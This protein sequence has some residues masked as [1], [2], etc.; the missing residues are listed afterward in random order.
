MAVR[1]ATRR[2]AD[3]GSFLREYPTTL[4][5]G[6]L[7]LPADALDGE[8][9]PELKVDLVLPL[10]GR[11]G[12][13]VG[14]VVAT[15]PDGGV[16]L[17]VPELPPPV[18]AALGE[19]M[20]VVEQVRTWLLESGQVLPKPLASDGA[21]PAPPAP[22]VARLRARVAE[23]E[24]RLRR[25]DAAGVAAP[26]GADDGDLAPAAGPL[27]ERG[28]TVP[29][30]EG[31]APALHGDL[32]DRSFRDALMAM[33]VEKQTGIVTLRR[34]DGRVRW[35]LWLKGGPVGWRT[36]PLEE[37]EVLGMLLFRAGTLTK[38]QLAESLAVMERNGCRQ[39]EALI[40]MGICTFPQVVLLLQKQ[41][42]FVL[43]RVLREREGTWSVHLLDELPERFLTPPVRVAAM[44]Y[45]SLTAY[46]RE[47]PAQ[48]LANALRPWLDQYVFLAPGVERTFEE[49]KL[50]A[51]E[52]QFVQIIQRTSYR[53]RELSAVSSLSRSQ[54][55]AAIWCL[56]DLNLIEFRAEATASR[57]NERFAKEIAARKIQSQGGTLFERLD[58]HWICT[59]AEVEAAF[60][61][62]STTWRPEKAARYGE[63]Y[64][65]I[66]VEIQ[67]SLEAARTVLASDASRREY[68]A[69][70]IEKGKI[71][72]SAEMLCRKGEMAV[73]KGSAREALDCYS[74]A[75]ELVPNNAEYTQ[76]VAQARAMPSTR[77]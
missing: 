20:G 21:V 9:A 47:M 30:L 11:V 68:R 14:Q 38:E 6:A 37:A 17:R 53:L 54:T 77:A 5:V 13:L 65:P 63:D 46:V 44:L 8:P 23:L 62:L 10:V 76:G 51:E 41:V 52:Q 72:Q 32:A 66:L 56:H 48:E 25:G 29:D 73:M 4:G 3:L 26:P 60:Q 1:Q 69:K 15:L 61:K 59:A 57:E 50:S 39:G 31:I 43:Q 27:R 40:D 74:K 7:V 16:A 22:D 49:M 12:P 71:D 58:L 33:A 28:L 70:I 24:A 42:D 36:E 2:Y 45:R 18:R 35:G 75:L 34:P 64:R 67:A 55:A 19:V